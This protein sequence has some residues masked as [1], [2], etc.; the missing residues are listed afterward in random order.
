MVLSYRKKIP[1]FNIYGY[2]FGHYKTN[3]KVTQDVALQQRTA[4][5]CTVFEVRVRS[6][7][8]FMQYPH[9]VTDIPIALYSA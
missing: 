5:L 1:I 7:S 3:K 9:N 8:C 4:L 6:T 2:L